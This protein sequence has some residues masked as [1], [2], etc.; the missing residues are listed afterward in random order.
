MSQRLFLVRHGRTAWNEGGRY[1]GGSDIDLDDAGVAQTE[2]LAGWAAASN[3]DAIVSSPAWRARHTASIVASRVGLDARV[4]E[5]LRE[6][7]FGAAEGRTLAELRAEAPDVVDRFV[8]DPIDH[9]LPGG[10]HPRAALERM[11]AAI[12]ELQTQP[13]ER[14]LVVT[15]GTV[16]RLLLCDCLGISLA[17]YRRLLPAVEHCAI[18][19]LA[20]L[21][22]AFALYQYNAAT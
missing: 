17:R 7:D 1:L 9:H 3:L 19:E 2:R 6:L 18:T 21:G 12:R 10:E 5:R 14:V 11:H 8:R 15:H 20:P 22:D 13:A 16:L 4:D